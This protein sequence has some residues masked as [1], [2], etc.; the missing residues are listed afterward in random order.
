M[1]IQYFS[2]FFAR[3]HV[4]VCVC[5]CVCVAL[6]LTA[7]LWVVVVVCLFFLG[8]GFCFF[9]G[10]CTSLANGYWGV[11]NRSCPPEIFPD[12]SML[13]R[14]M[15]YVTQSNREMLSCVNRL[16]SHLVDT[17]Y[18]LGHLVSSA[19]ITFRNKE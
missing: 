10:N 7:L 13:K 12:V 9:F 18:F 15:L 6:R 19:R 11:S 3:A 17:N 2:G 4:A 14:S 8:G 1:Y 16:A 5:V